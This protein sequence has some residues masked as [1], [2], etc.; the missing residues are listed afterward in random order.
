M[1]LGLFGMAVVSACGGFAGPYGYAE[2]VS[3]ACRRDSLLHRLTRLKASGRYDHPYSCPAGPDTYP[4]NHVIYFFC[5]P[6]NRIL[7]VAVVP[8][9][10]NEPILLVA[11]KEPRP[12]SAWEGFNHGL[13]PERQKAITRWFYAGVNPFLQCK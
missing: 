12:E 8:G 11:A 6:Q 4:A 13:D 1:A 3:S 9:F 2:G 10:D 5:Q 7:Y